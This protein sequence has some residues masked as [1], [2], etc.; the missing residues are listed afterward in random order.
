MVYITVWLSIYLSYIWA[1]IAY[2]QDSLLLT[3]VPNLVRDFISNFQDQRHV[4]NFH[5]VM[6]QLAVILNNRIHD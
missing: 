4:C 5:E 3:S 2:I 6:T 1:F